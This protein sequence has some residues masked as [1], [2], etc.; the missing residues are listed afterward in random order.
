[1]PWQYDKRSSDVRRWFK[2]RHFADRV[3]HLYSF[4]CLCSIPAHK[5]QLFHR[6]LLWNAPR[7]C[8]RIQVLIEMAGGPREASANGVILVSQ[9]VRCRVSTLLTT[10]ALICIDCVG[11]LLPFHIYISYFSSSFSHYLSLSLSLFNLFSLPLFLSSISS[12][13]HSFSLQSLSLSL[14]FSHTQ[15]LFFFSLEILCLSISG[16]W[17]G[18]IERLCILLARMT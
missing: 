14:A 16:N 2:L 18:F 10:R 1:M 6:T 13:S 7:V 4:A 3:V 5:S 12:L 8:R 9:V 15:T 17:T 11:L